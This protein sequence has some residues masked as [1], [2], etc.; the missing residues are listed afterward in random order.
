MH[1]DQLK[2]REFITLLGGAVAAWPL[3]ARA[4]AYPSRPVRIVVGFPAGGPNDFHARLMGQWLS[5]QLG[6][7]FVV[8]NRPGAGGNT[9]TEAVV[10]APTGRLYPPVGQFARRDQRD[11]L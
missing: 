3:A 11:A 8:E 7:Q 4:Q 5:E 6:Q 10:R 9:G 1:F 2:R